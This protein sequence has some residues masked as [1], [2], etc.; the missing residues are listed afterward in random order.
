MISTAVNIKE[1]NKTHLHYINMETDDTRVI[2]TILT[3]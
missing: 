2:G 1:L 3:L